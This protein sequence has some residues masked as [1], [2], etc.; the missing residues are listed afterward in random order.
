MYNST[1]EVDQRIGRLIQMHA[2]RQKSLQEAKCGDIVGVV[3]LSKT[4]TGD[5]LCCREH[6]IVLESIE[7]PSP[8]VSISI[9]PKTRS[10]SDRM[11]EALHDLSDEDPTFIVGYDS[12]TKETIISG[13]GEL[14]LE[15]LVERLK[16]EFSVHADVSKPEVA[17]RE[18]GTCTVKGDYKHVKQTGGRGQYAHVCMKLEPLEPGTGFEFVNAVKGG[19]IPSE[20][21]PAVEKGIIAAMT[22]GPYAGYPVVDMR[23]TVHDGSSHDVDSSEYAFTEAA[24][25]CFRQL[26]MQSRPSLLEPVMSLEVTAPDEYVGDVSGSICKRRGRIESMD[27][28]EGY[29][30]TR[31]MAPLSEMFG[32]ANTLRT[33]TQGRGDFTMHF[34]HY[35]VVPFSIAEEIINK[36]REENNIR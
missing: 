21:I 26:F 28:R 25:V 4:K 29:R 20:Y 16:R 8:V 35:E 31:G 23:V 24:R 22:A 12:D 6:P 19:K 18:T 14:H 5:T 32:Y 27:E 3:G 2:N 33:L 9:S 30:I 17:H 1:K 36:R 10:D 7:F 13:M 15:V 11:G 34:E